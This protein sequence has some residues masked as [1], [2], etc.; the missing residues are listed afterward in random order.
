M[1]APTTFSSLSGSNFHT[2][3]LNYGSYYTTPT[4]NQNNNDLYFYVPTCELNGFR[5]HSCSIS[6]TTITMRFQQSIANG[7]EMT[8]RFSIVNPYDEGD[9]GFILNTLTDGTIV[10][11]IQITP[12]AGTTFYLEMEPFH[13]FYRT[14]SAG[15]AYPSMGISNVALLWGTQAQGQ[16]NYL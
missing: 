14:T 12:H 3:S 6:S 16:L 5:I 15:A 1:M 8:V 9:E 7:R 4:L 13:P 10:M 11:P 2:I